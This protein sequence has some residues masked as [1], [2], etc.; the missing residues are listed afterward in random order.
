MALV[1]GEAFVG[2]AANTP[3]CGAVSK[4]A[5]DSDMA[6]SCSSPALPKN[7]CA[8]T[9]PPP[10]LAPSP[11]LE[12]VDGLNLTDA[13]L[14]KVR[15]LRALVDAL[16]IVEEI[17]E[18]APAVK[19][20]GW[21]SGLFSRSSSNV[22]KKEVR[23]LT[24]E[25]VLWLANDL[26]LW[27]Y[28]RSYS[29]D[30]NQAQQQLMQ[31]I[32][33]RRNRKPHCIHPDDVKATAARGSVYRKGFDIHGHPIVYFKPGREPAQ[34]TK[35][36][37]EYTLYTMEK[38]IQSIN[39]AKGRDQL[40]FLVDFTGFSITQVPSMDLSKE[41]VNILNDHYTDIL[42]KAYMLDAP[43]Y[44][45]AVWKF[46][47]VMLHPLT[48]SKVEFIQTSNKKQ[49]AKLMEHIPAEFLEES[50]GGSC[51]VVYDHQKYWMAEDKYHADIARHTKDTIAKMKEDEAFIGRLQTATSLQ[52]AAAQ[53]PL[54]A[55]STTETSEEQ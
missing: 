50:L 31:T 7:V 34:S 49:L 36:A 32:A 26:V 46:V 25:E 16:P 22:T 53:E 28:L 54:L 37:Q 51:G 44:F 41:V 27:R 2:S 18:E 21:L 9:G 23:E 52:L 13:Q 43:S 11:P 1:E 10:F 38:A 33:W 8:N 15:A 24:W 47:K 45:D 14:A 55:K 20:K 17:P 29:W 3:A 48:A 39:K 12:F 42:A 30:Q 6:T 4:A 40:V 35:A 19:D 5:S